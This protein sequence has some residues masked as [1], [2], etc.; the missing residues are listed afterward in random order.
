MI[1]ITS[2]KKMN[3]SFFNSQEAQGGRWF[4]YSSQNAAC[5]SGVHSIWEGLTHLWALDASES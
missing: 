1:D 2:L 3:S 5:A 4:Y